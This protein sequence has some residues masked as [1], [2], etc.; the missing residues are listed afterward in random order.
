MPADSAPAC[1]RLEGEVTIASVARHA[2]A[3][4]AAFEPGRPVD[5]DLESVTHLDGAGVQLLMLAAREALLRDVPLRV[6]AASRAVR[7]ALDLAGL[8]DALQPRGCAC[9]CAEAHA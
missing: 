6:S 4:V 9:T 3:L 8:D 1:L 5:L 7:D 2:P